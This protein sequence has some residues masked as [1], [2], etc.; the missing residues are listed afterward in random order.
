[1]ENAEEM[2][3]NG[4][5]AEEEAK[6]F[7]PWIVFSTSPLIFTSAQKFYRKSYARCIFRDQGDQRARHGRRLSTHL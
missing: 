5:N 7:H 6:C 1:M 3:F 4:C 2:R